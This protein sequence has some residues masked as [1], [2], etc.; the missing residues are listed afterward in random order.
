MN[1]CTLSVAVDNEV[2]LKNY[3]LDYFVL[4]AVENIF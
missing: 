3:Y 1:R 2:L 4:I